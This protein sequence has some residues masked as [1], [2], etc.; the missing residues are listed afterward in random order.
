M[1]L[2]SLN[3]LV[4]LSDQR[5]CGVSIAYYFVGKWWG[6]I[7]KGQTEPHLDIYYPEGGI[8]SLEQSYVTHW[9]FLPLDPEHQE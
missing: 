2:E 7:R 9:M 4:Y 6:G 3:V 8:S 5:N 1:P